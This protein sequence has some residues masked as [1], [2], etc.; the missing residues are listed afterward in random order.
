MAPAMRVEVVFS[1]FYL[2]VA[3]GPHPLRKAWIFSFSLL[4]LGPWDAG[5]PYKASAPRLDRRLAR[6]SS[7]LLPPML[8]TGKHGRQT[9][10]STARPR[11]KTRPFP[12]KTRL[13]GRACEASC[14]SLRPKSALLC[15]P[16]P[17]HLRPLH[18]NPD[19]LASTG[20]FSPRS[21]GRR[22]SKLLCAGCRADGDTLRCPCRLYYG[23]ARPHR[24]HVPG[25][26]LGAGVLRPRA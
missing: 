15:P 1:T 6:Q 4:R 10:A 2:P 11:S 22:S 23:L 8:S 20:S 21:L 24:H 25:E 9:T 12:S 13:A 14:A 7:T 26:G 17:Q 16:P 5:I 19:S 3:V 18:G